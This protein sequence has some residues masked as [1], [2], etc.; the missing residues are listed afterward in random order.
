MKKSQSI[1]LFSGLIPLVAAP[2]AIV[3]SCSSDSTATTF[4][5]KTNVTLTGLADDQK[6]PNQYVGA[7]NKKKL[8][9]LIVAKRDQIFNNPPTDLKAEQI[10]IINDVTANTSDGSLTFKLKVVSTATPP[11]CLLYT[12]DAADD[13]QPV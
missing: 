2:I 10:Q 13:L 4:S 7:D 5:L 9:D 8:A 12:S 6:D 11:T 1:F 3:A